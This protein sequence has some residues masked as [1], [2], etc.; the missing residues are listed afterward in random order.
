MNIL[1]YVF[2]IEL[3][4]VITSIRFEGR[5]HREW[6][7]KARGMWCCLPVVGGCIVANFHMHSSVLLY[8]NSIAA[9]FV[10]LLHYLAYIFG[11]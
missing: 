4:T 8:V 5:R 6:H 10:A 7:E 2:H 9:T 11:H 3:A 1:L